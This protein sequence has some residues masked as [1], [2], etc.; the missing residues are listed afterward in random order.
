MVKAIIFLSWLVLMGHIIPPQLSA[1]N[2]WL[3]SSDEGP[4]K[5]RGRD[6]SSEDEERDAKRKCPVDV[7]ADARADRLFR[8][9]STLS[10]S[11]F[12]ANLMKYFRTKVPIN[13]K[14]K[15]ESDDGSQRIYD[16]LTKFNEDELRQIHLHRES[17]FG[18]FGSILHCAATIEILA[19]EKREKSINIEL[20]ANGITNIEDELLLFDLLKKIKELAKEAAA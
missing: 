12:G 18:R 13:M 20:F 19:E 15:N 14:Y 4:S 1:S 3:S 16:Q 17:I 9:A 8:E 10:M 5:K 7:N 11:E 6:E 2:D